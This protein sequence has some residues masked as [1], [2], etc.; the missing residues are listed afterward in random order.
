M[1]NFPHPRPQEAQVAIGCEGR[2]VSM[3]PDE[4]QIALHHALLRISGW[5]ADD[6][7]Y[8][9]R[10]W[11]GTGNVA[12][13]A[14]AVTFALRSGEVPLTAGDITALQAALP[15]GGH[16]A[17]IL[18]GL[19]AAVDIVDSVPMPLYVMLPVKSPD[20]LTAAETSPY[21]LD[22]TGE[23]RDASMIDEA[24]RAVVSAASEGGGSRCPQAVWRAWRYPL[25]STPWPA[26]RRVYLVQTA[27]RP[28]E[29]LPQLT[30]RL[31]RALVRVR[32]HAPLVEVFTKSKELP[33]YQRTALEA[34]ALLW[35]SQSLPPVRIAV[36]FDPMR[37]VGGPGFT[38][39]R[40]KLEPA[41]RDRVL[42]Y[43][44]EASSVL[45]TTA[46]MDD[47]IDERRTGAVPLG[48]RTDGHWIWSDAAAYYLRRY[49]FCPD[50]GLL[51][52]IRQRR[53][54]LPLVDAVAHHRGLAALQ[55]A[56][57]DDIE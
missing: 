54:E 7:L 47:V 50:D 45:T 22:L 14:Q 51:D 26:P 18:S 23:S 3:P 25:V 31:H 13:V 35:T 52:H 29:S 24:D 28:D 37:N 42:A 1:S 12:D 53:Y 39:G 46:V 48:F 27:V 9:A 41:E 34:A 21:S 55:A 20:P 15:T 43:L 4:L 10:E 36:L 57:M 40:P 38:A 11:L 19:L 56:S 44:D 2:S 49:G 32:E 6:L 16:G 30:V 8:H 33:P 5:A 17:D